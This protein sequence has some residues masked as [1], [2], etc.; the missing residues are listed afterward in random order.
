MDSTSLDQMRE[1]N[2]STE[3]RDF[4]QFTGIPFD[5]LMCY[6]IGNISLQ[7]RIAEYTNQI[8]SGENIVVEDKP[9]NTHEWL[10]LGNNLTY[11]RK[12]NIN[13]NVGWLVV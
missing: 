4:H 3:R 9:E 7:S 6:P 12:P 10:R 11:N 5:A 1:Y 13:E 8:R 2:I